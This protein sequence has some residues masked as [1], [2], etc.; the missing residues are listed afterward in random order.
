VTPLRLLIQGSIPYANDDW[1]IGRF[2]FLVGYLASLRD[3]RGNREVQVLA[4][5]RTPD[6][7]GSDP[8]LRRLSRREFDEVWLFGLDG[9]EGL[10]AE[11]RAAVDEF[12]RSGGGVL[13]ARDHQ[14]MGLWI[15]KLHGVGGAHFFHDETCREP[16]PTRWR[17]DDSQTL[18]IDFPNYHSGANGD[19][20]RILP[21]EPVHPLL[22]REGSGTP[23][24]YLPA[25]PHEGA[26][27]APKIEPRA[28]SVAQG[29]STVTG[30]L[31]DLSVA[32][33]RSPEFP[34]R[35]VAESSFHHFAD[36]NW[37]IARG[38]PSFVTEPSG[39]GMRE[40]PEALA[41]TQT[42]VRNLVHWLAPE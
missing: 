4:R 7:S 8:F 17:R 19:F 23:I 41:D 33:E 37:D 36:Y 12:Q 20:Q 34:G 28:R 25:H 29:K 26:V 32:F 18:S 9:G 31:F 39:T 16:D 30:Q 10:N 21:V 40:N 42:Y 35:G 15:R 13:T 27:Q 1:H 11:E 24:R 5:D 22:R 6:G 38:A 14:D 3:A 2:S